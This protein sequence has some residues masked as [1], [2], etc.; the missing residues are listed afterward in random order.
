MLNFKLFSS[1]EKAF[2]DEKVID[3][4]EY[5]Y[6]NY[7]SECYVNVEKTAQ[8]TDNP[9]DNRHKRCNRDNRTANNGYDKVN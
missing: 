7:H 9:A 5:K 3:F 4:K 2:L 6:K 8:S 1:L